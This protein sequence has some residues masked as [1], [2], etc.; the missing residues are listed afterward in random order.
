MPEDTIKVPKIGEW[1]LSESNNVALLN[2]ED[3]VKKL[4]KRVVPF[5][6]S[7]PL[8]TA[9]RKR[10]IMTKDTFNAPIDDPQARPRTSAPY[11]LKP[12]RIITLIPEN[13]EPKVTFPDGTVTTNLDDILKSKYREMKRAL[14]PLKGRGKDEKVP[15][16][17]LEIFDDST[18]EEYPLE[19]LMKDPRA[20]S[21]YQDI[22]GEKL[23]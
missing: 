3:Q 4:P 13:I 2:E 22:D 18:Y 5:P 15:F 6:R 8:N 1:S 20:F 11:I 9:Q 21:R 19:V 7:I 17:P 14:P 12:P 16:M 23:S 10:L